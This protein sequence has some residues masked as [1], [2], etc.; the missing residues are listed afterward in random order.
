MVT[1]HDIYDIHLLNARMLKFNL[2]M[3]IATRMSQVS[4]KTSKYH[5]TPRRNSF[6]A[7]VQ[8]NEKERGVRDEISSFW[9]EI[10]QSTNNFINT[11]EIDEELAK[12]IH[13]VFQSQT[14]LKTGSIELSPRKRQD[15]DY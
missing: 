15:T 10:R 14:M 1:L 7:F 9:D 8:K 5:K 2:Y 13:N 12:K 11:E 6:D 3:C 4:Q